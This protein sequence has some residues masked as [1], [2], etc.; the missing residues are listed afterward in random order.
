M[1]WDLEKKYIFVHIPKTGGTK[2][3]KELF[4]CI[5]NINKG[6]GVVNNKA[7][8][9]YS[10]IEIINYLNKKFKIEYND[11]NNFYKFTIVRNPYTRFISEYYWPGNQYGYYKNKTID[12]FINVI[13]NKLN[14][15]SFNDN[16]YEDHH[17][18]QY[19]YIYD[20]NNK[21]CVNEIFKFENFDKIINK[22]NLSNKIIHKCSVNNKLELNEEQKNRIYKMYEKDFELFNYFK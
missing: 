20:D 8:Q 2:I 4:N 16:D 6:Y 5:N 19:K 7:M 13:E 21:I 15:N 17:Y 1:C 10:I 18:Q 9:H 3:E 12:E 22:F 11:I 14:N